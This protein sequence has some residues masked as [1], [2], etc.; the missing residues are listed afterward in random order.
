M[1]NDPIADLLTRVRNA[2]LRKL[3][4]LTAPHSQVKEDITKIL[5]DEGY[6]LDF[7]VQGEGVNKEI[8]I[9]L[10]YKGTQKVITGLK[11]ISKPGLRV[12]QPADKLPRVLNGFGTA[13]ISTSKGIMTA[14]KA[15]KAKLGGEVMAFV[16]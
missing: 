8:L 13:I 15:R 14:D 16:W 5:L 9:Y 11:R 6:I 4:S 10:K 12:Y 1:I 2:N 3:K 7:K